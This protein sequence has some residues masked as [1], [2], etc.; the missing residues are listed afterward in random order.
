MFSDND[1]VL[2]I[3]FIVFLVWGVFEAFLTVLYKR[4]QKRN[5]QS[6]NSAHK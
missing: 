1:I 4:Q 3:L 2:M 6:I 5:E